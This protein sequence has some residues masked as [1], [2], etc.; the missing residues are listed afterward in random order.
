MANLLRRTSKLMRQ[1]FNCSLNINNVK[2]PISSTS[3]FQSNNDLTNEFIE[4]F[5]KYGF[6]ILQCKQDA[7]YSAAECLEYNQLNMQY[8]FGSI[9]HYEKADERGFVT[10]NSLDPTS[11]QVATAT[12]QHLPHTDGA[13]SPNPEKIVTLGCMVPCKSGG[14][15]TIL[16][17][18]QNIIEYIY[19]LCELEEDYYIGYK[20]MFEIDCITIGRKL[21]NSDLYR[22]IEKPILK[23]IKWENKNVIEMCYR[24]DRHVLRMND[25][26]NLTKLWDKIKLFVDNEQNQLKYQLKENEIAVLDNYSVLHGRSTFEEGELRIMKRMNFEND[27]KGMLMDYIQNGM[28]FIEVSTSMWV[29]ALPRSKQNQIIETL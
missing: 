29:I 4:I 28:V 13:Y 22:E 19:N 25:N 17:S 7:N 8:L 16:V 5:N 11:Y 14:G 10:I 12:E 15:Q 6:V 27:K 2:L 9:S 23:S 18:G 24:A 20:K 21:L 26:E 3:H 1:P